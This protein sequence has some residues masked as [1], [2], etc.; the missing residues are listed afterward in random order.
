MAITLCL[1]YIQLISVTFKIFT[2]LEE[3]DLVHRVL[4]E[5]LLVEDRA[6]AEVLGEDLVLAEV[7]GEDRALVTT[8]KTSR[9]LDG[10]VAAEGE[11]RCL[12]V[13]GQNGSAADLKIVIDH[14]IEIAIVIAVAAFFLDLVLANQALGAREDEEI[15]RLIQLLI[16]FLLVKKLVGKNI[17]G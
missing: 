13:S 4:A 17:T 16:L 14:G 15:V 2:D 5:V 9:Q 6:S 3:E 7:L 8:T 1:N 12:E 11:V 10:Q